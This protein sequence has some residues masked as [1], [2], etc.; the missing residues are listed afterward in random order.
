MRDLYAVQKPDGGNLPR[1]RVPEMKGTAA[2]PGKR[3]SPGHRFWVGGEGHPALYT[4]RPSCVTHCSAT[5]A[6]GLAPGQGEVDQYF[7]IHF[8]GFTVQ[9]IRFVL[10]LLHGVDGSGSQH[11]M[12]ADQGQTL[13]RTILADHRMQDHRTL[14]AGLPRQRRIIRLY[15]PDQQSLGY[16]LGHAD[17]LRRSDLGHGYRGRTDDTADHAAHLA[18]RNA[19][20][21]ASDY[22]ARR[23][24]RRRSFVFFDHLHFLRNLG[25]RAQFAVHDIGLNLLHD[26]DWRCS[27]GWWRWWWRGGNQEGH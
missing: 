10:P 14:D 18:A 5:S 13:D 4:F 23:H 7:R 27:R 6:S 26:F 25:R 19:S 22:A 15:A 8:D 1:T 20:R 16:A 17:A 9:Q 2:A 3:C 12:S 11:G 21:N 24:H